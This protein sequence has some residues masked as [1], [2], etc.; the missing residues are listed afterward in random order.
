[1]K[2]MLS[3]WFTRKIISPLVWN[4]LV[5]SVL[6]SSPH[7]NWNNL[8]RNKASGIKKQDSV[9]VYLIFQDQVLG[10]SCYAVLE[11]PVTFDDQ[12]LLVCIQQ[13]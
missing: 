6:K 7:L 1:M 4:D 10:E 8:W 11:R 2:K 5:K 12:T 9:R 13:V 3:S